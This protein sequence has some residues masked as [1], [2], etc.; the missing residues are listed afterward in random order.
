MDKSITAESMLELSRKVV[1][2]VDTVKEAYT[3]LEDK[4]FDVNFRQ[5]IIGALVI[6]T[7]RIK[8]S[9]P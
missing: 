8:V 6:I 3:F 2:Y 7:A 9:I 5:S 1:G 4:D